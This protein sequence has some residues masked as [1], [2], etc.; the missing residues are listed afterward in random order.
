MKK[1]TRN[2]LSTLR[3]DLLA[4][5]AIRIVPVFEGHLTLLNLDDS[6]IGWSPDGYSGP[7]IQ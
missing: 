3:G 7:G 2:K 4:F 1:K 5:V 6:L